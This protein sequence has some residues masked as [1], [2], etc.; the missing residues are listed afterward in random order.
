[1]RRYNLQSLFGKRKTLYLSLGIML[2]SVLSL[3]VVYAALSQ[4]LNISGS[5]E[6]AAS[7]WDIYLDNVI[8]RTGSV[9]A[10]AP[11][12]SGNN[13]SFTANLLKPGDYYE[14]S[15][16][17]VN[18]GTIDA[19][20]DSIVKT[21]ELTAEQSKFFK[22]EAT[23]QN[24]DPI[25]T[26]QTLKT[27]TRT[28]L[29]V[30][31]EFRKD[32]TAADLPKTTTSLNLK[33][34]LVY[35]QSDGTGS[36]INNN[37]VATDLEK[38]TCSLTVQGSRY[39]G[40]YNTPPTIT[41]NTSPGYSEITDYII[42]T[43]PAPNLNSINYDN[44]K[45][46]TSQ[47]NTTGTTW[48]GYAKDAMGNVAQCST[49]IKV[50]TTPPTTPSGGSISVSGSNP[51][52]TLGAVSGSND[53]TGSGNIQYRYLVQKNTT[54]V[55]DKNS[56][57]FTTSQTFTRACGTT[58]Y[59]YA[60]AVDEA[61]NKSN[62]YQIGTAS[63]ARDEYVNFSECSKVCG[64]G[65]QSAQSEC[66]L[67]TTTRTVSCNTIDCCSSTYQSGRYTHNCTKSCGVGTQDVYAY[68]Y[69]NYNG[70]SCGSV[71]V[72]TQYCNTHDC[73]DL[74]YYQDGTI[75]SCSD[76]STTGTYNR[77]AYSTYDGTRC[78]SRD[79]ASGGDSCPVRTLS[80]SS[81]GA[82]GLTGCKQFGS[83]FSI[84]GS[85]AYQTGKLTLCK[86]QTAL[87]SCVAANPTTCQQ[88]GTT[89]QY[90][91]NCVMPS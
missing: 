58:Y 68:L 84:Y 55:P 18:D 44:V 77:L 34:T 61:G 62:V 20:I 56:G 21:P 50:D 48:Y 31:V 57:L 12:I 32:L 30:R 59:A 69:S 13:L 91:K 33:L 15:V 78:A 79:Q 85:T 64:G 90:I 53:G 2:I 52:A 67:I 22:F 81:L 9:S 43:N 86:S 10:N 73:C 51:T 74:V 89:Y 45:T 41:I 1:M 25:A 17:V 65:T 8:V 27:K 24:G 76:S 49:H 66:P 29:I 46:K 54:N 7:N 71:K 60:V 37:G 14:F 11:S 80:I 70:Q 35:V 47:S 72:D 3:T 82:S 4:V 36:V 16:D 40:W 87:S 28:P 23:Y 42:T 5:T 63:D 19:M 26:K 88:F 38:P 83:T 39:N 6:I 75:C